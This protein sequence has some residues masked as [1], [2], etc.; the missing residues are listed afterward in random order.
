MPRARAR[1]IVAAYGEWCAVATEPQL[2][3]SASMLEEEHALA[4]W[5]ALIVQA[6]IQTGAERLVSE[7]LQDGRRFGALTIENP[8]RMPRQRPG[9]DGVAGPPGRAGSAPGI[10][11]S[12]TR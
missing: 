3:V 7:D 11:L 2:T 10:M 6:A 9:H 12:R 1:A 4:F 5:D 8:F